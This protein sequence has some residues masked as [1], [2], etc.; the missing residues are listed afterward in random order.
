MS[1]S[2]VKPVLTAYAFNLN[3]A[4]RLVAD[5]SDRQM[6]ALPM[7]GMNHPA[8]VLGHLAITCDFVLSLLERPTA[9]PAEWQGLFGA[10]TQPTNRPGTYPAKEAL[11]Q[12]LA[13][14]HARVATAYEA[15]DPVTLEKPTPNSR[16]RRVFLTV[17]ESVVGMLTTH[18]AMHLGQVSAWRR[19][20]GL[21]SV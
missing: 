10:G 19:G 3:Y 8:W 11:L 4:Q 7:P 21:P 18:E 14:G 20:Q 13:D 1:H 5:L 6:C 2:I 12:A 9:G 16:M 17:G 15:A